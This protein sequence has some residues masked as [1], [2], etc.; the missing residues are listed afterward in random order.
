MA[1][2]MWRC[3]APFAEIRGAMSK[4]LHTRGEA[5]ALLSMSLDH[6]ERHVQPHVRLVRTGR[7]R[8]VPAAELER[9]VAERAA[10][11]GDGS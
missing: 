3:V 11:A 10:F 8:L 7:L 4:L 2:V 9:F 6:F 5:S 1:S